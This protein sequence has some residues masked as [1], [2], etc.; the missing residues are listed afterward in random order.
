MTEP[1][2]EER[3]GQSRK[4]LRLSTTWVLALLT[5]P[6]AIVVFFYG[7]GAVM[8]MA[9]CADDACAHQGPSQFWFGVLFYGAPVVPVVTIAISAFTARLRYGMWVPIVGLALLLID[10]IV[11][12]VTF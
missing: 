11:L 6:A 3:Q 4:H 12:A 9:G 7:M 1:D 10:F 2:I 5:I 8:S